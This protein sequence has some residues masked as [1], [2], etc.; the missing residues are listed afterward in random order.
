MSSFTGRTALISAVAGLILF[1]S[2]PAIAEYRHGYKDIPR[3]VDVPPHIVACIECHNQASAHVF[4]NWAMDRHAMSGVL[5]L[6]CHGVG[7]NDDILHEHE[8][9]YENGSLPYGDPKYK[10]PIST[11]VTPEDC[12]KCHPYPY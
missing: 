6:E 5:C 8:M 1:L 2:L 7:E 4:T 9:H 3:D 10:V 12:V 11:A